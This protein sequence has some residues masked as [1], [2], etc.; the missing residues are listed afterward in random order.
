MRLPW[1]AAQRRALLERA[2]RLMPA[3]LEDPRAAA[4]LAE[5]RRNYEEGLPR[6]FLSRCPWTG[7]LLRFAFDPL[8]LDGLWWDCRNPARPLRNR[9]Y[10]CQAVTGAVLLDGQIEPFPFLAKPGPA[11]PYVIPRLLL[12]PEVKAVISAAPCGRHRAWCVAYFAPCDKP[13]L[14]WPNDWGA[15]ERQV[16]RAGGAWAR[17]EALDAEEEWDFDL[18]PWIRF[19]KLAWIA[20]GDPALALRYGLE[21]CPYAALAGARRMQYVQDGEVWT[22]DAVAGPAAREVRR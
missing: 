21:G 14:A 7:L 5:V 3:A 11:A 4:E 17:E 1:G 8:G 9:I 19:G 6:L 16:E 20:P 22:R 15:N 10:S 18:A 13:G 2:F 12:D